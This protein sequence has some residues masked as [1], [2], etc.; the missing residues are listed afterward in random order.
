MRQADADFASGCVRRFENE[1]E[2]RAFTEEIK[3]NGRVRLAAKL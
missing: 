1:T 2:L 3:T